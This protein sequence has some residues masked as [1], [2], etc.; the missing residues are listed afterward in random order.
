MNLDTAGLQA[1]LAVAEHGHFGRAAGAIHVTQTALSRRLQK[2]EGRLGVRLVERTTRSV[3]LTPIGRDFLPHA[4]RLVAELADAL[5]EIRESGKAQRG[6]VTIACVPTVGVQY[7][8]RIIQ[9]YAARHPGNRIRLLDHASARVAVAVQHREAEF[10]ITLMGATGPDL[11]SVPL[12]KDAFALVCPARHPFARRRRLPWRELRGSTLIYCGLESGN[13]HLLDAALAQ[14]GV[15]VWPQYEVQRSSTAVGLVAAGVGVAVV[16][17][18]AMQK[19][20]Y[21]ELRVV[22]LCEPVVTRHMVLVSRRNAWLTPPA[23]ALYD[24][25]RRNANWRSPTPP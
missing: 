12:L 10:G 3:A 14:Q 2:L 8:P 22:P 11:E 25:I 4:R 13:R 17:Q 23:R 5:T 21:P 15:Q 24:L 19:G 9:Q 20:A 1:F 16:P 7:L 6:E 18:L